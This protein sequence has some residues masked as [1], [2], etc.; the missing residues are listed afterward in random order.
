MLRLISIKLSLLVAFL[1]CSSALLSSTAFAKAIKRRTMPLFMKG[2]SASITV[3]DRL[4]LTGQ[5]RSL[6]P[7]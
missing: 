4:S 2:E 5:A 1:S 6:K 3:K 7:S